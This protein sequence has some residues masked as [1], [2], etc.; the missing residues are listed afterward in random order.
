MNGKLQKQGFYR[1][2]IR[3][4]LCRNLQGEAGF[5]HAMGKG[6]E[7]GGIVLAIGGGVL[8]MSL[9]HK[10]KVS[11]NSGKDAEHTKESED[12]N[13]TV[14]ESMKPTLATILKNTIKVV[15]SIVKDDLKAVVSVDN[16]DI[17]YVASVSI[18]LRDFQKDA[19]E[20]HTSVTQ[21]II[22]RISTFPVALLCECSKKLMAHRD[23]RA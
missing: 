13:C 8:W 10:D 4:Q 22:E 1:H 6:R 12:F 7:Y 19:F 20:S 2:R 5:R 14:A 21:R 17:K 18:D 3:K 23:Q 9:Y 15:A 11:F 16:N